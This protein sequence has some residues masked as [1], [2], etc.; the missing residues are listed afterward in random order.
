MHQELFHVLQQKYLSTVL[1]I[2][3]IQHYK[4]METTVKSSHTVSLQS[5]ETEH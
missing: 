1:L 2:S 3:A 5:S 4:W